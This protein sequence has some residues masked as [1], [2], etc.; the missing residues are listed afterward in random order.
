M[1]KLAFL[2]LAIAVLGTPLRAE[3]DKRLEDARQHADKAKMHY[4]LGEFEQAANEYILVYRIK[5]IPALLYNIAQAYRQAGQYEKAKQFYRSYLSENPEPK[6][7]AALEKAI[8]EIDELIAKEKKTR[9]AKPIGMAKEP[10]VPPPSSPEKVAVVP[11][12][13]P[14]PAQKPPESKPSPPPVKP[15]S[16]PAPPASEAGGKIA[17]LG[18]PPAGRSEKPAPDM[19]KPPTRISSPGATTPT[20]R[21]R[22]LTWIAAG[23]TVAAL[24]AGGAFGYKA[25]DGA[26]S[27]DAQKANILYG[28]GGV[29]AITTAA[30]FIFEF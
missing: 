30:L 22:T 17:A 5:P 3:D 24:A 21:S 27:S 12:P 18:P 14:V 4:R 29:L 2:A 23:A 20:K 8:K 7:R 25:I 9:E 26:S 16:P 15:P 13:A 11:A 28:A 6:I 19:A 10:V 1:S